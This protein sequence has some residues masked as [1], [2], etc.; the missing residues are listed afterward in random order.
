MTEKNII[1]QTFLYDFGEGSKYQL[2]FI[3]DTHLE[4]TIVE[5]GFYTPGTVN[6]FDIEITS[7]S[8]IKL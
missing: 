1:G 8:I 6:H 3:D 4:V 2:H 5:D 7:K